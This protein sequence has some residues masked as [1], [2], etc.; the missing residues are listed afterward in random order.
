VPKLTSIDQQKKGQQPPPPPPGPDHP[1]SDWKTFLRVNRSGYIGDVLNITLALKFAPEWSGLFGW[2]ES[3]LAVTA[4]RQPVFAT[5]ETPPFHWGEE[6]NTLLSAWLLHEGFASVSE[7]TLERA[8]KAVAVGHPFHKV[9]KYL[10]SLS[11]DQ[12]HRIDTWLVDYL[13]V[14][15]SRFARAVGAK[16]L[17]AAVSRAMTPGSKVDDVLILEGKQGLRK[18]MLLETLGGPG[19]F[20]DNVAQ[21]GTRDA[22]DQSHGVWIIE[23]Q[24]IDKILK[25]AGAS[26][27]KSHITTKVDHYRGAYQRYKKLA[28]RDSIML[29]TTNKEQY[30]IDESGNRRYWPVWCETADVEGI[31]AVRDQ[32]WAE[33][34]ARFLAG[35]QWWLTKEEEA[36]AAVE[37]KARMESHP[38]DEV[39]LPFIDGKK[40][41]SL[42]EMFGAGGPLQGKERTANA[43]MVVVKILRSEGWIQH[44]PSGKKTGSRSRRYYAASA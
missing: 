12:R 41:V 11:W 3:W 2:D 15:D 17:I 33:A 42:A 7:R 13:A 22:Q 35:E 39:V 5:R 21:F 32:L 31:K 4:L 16:W 36:M 43:D 44:R 28:P 9:R 34:M 29:G 38:W 1:R 23:I 8:V 19:F 30:L 24:E 14:K 27:A 10:K 37:Q 25:G 18:S 26:K 20:T 40:S 6:H